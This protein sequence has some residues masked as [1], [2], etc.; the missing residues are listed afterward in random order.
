MK[1][2]PLKILHQRLKK[3]IE[4]LTQEKEI[5][6]MNKRMKENSKPN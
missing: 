4:K 5:L 2:I 1:L 6:E 3:D